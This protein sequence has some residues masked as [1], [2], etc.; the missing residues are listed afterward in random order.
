MLC[1]MRMINSVQSHT[2]EER[3]AHKTFTIF[4]FYTL[5]CSYKPCTFLL[6]DMLSLNT[7]SAKN[8]IKATLCGIRLIP[9][10][11][12]LNEVFADSCDLIT[13]QKHTGD[14]TF[15]SDLSVILAPI[16]LIGDCLVHQRFDLTHFES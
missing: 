14:I 1:L 16:L 3:Y 12:Q 7:M 10:I 13:I 9:T 11:E 5:N 4:G 6:K 8:S 2:R 15:C